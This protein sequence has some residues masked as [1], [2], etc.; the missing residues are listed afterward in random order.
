MPWIKDMPIDI[1]MTADISQIIMDII[2]GYKNCL[3]KFIKL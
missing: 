2:D 1:W 3:N